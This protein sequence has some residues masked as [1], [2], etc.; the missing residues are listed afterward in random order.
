MSRGGFYQ[1]R[2]TDLSLCGVITDRLNILGVVRL[3]VSLGQNTPVMRLDSYVTSSFSLLSDGLLGLSS[4]K[5]NRIVI[6]PHS[7]TVKFQGRCFKAM[8]PWR[9]CPHKLRISRYRIWQ[10]LSVSMTS[11]V[12][13]YSLGNQLMK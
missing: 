7:N 9:K 6:V 11:G 5:S 12:N 10:Q 4:L 1:L 2:P 8:A 3:P 13:S